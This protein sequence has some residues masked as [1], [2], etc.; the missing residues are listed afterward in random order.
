MNRTKLLA[1]AFPLLLL[2]IAAHPAAHPATVQ[3]QTQASLNAPRQFEVASIKPSK[4]GAA[5]QDARLNFVGGRFEALNVTLNDVLYSFCGFSGKVQGGPKWTESDRYDILA[6][7]DGAIEPGEATLIRLN[8][9]RQVI[10]QAVNMG[11]LANY[12]HQIW[13]TTVVDHTGIAGKFD[14]T[15]ELDSVAP[16]ISGQSIPRQDSF[17]DLLRAAIEQSCFR[18]ETQRVTV[19]ITV[20]DHVERL[21]EN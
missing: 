12:L 15:I 11:R 5:V 2:A 19:D 20:I 6:K 21:S 1:P 18:V 10:F 13:R 16:K 4:P 3:P 7:F 14:F 9:R 17:A 8:D